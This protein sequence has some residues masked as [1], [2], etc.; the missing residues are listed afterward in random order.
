[1]FTYKHQ[2]LHFPL[3]F[4]SHLSLDPEASKDGTLP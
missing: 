4:K 2:S 3:N 1:M